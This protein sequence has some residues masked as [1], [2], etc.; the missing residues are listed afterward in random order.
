VS[1]PA[2][3]KMGDI[4]E[5]NCDKPLLKERDTGALVKVVIDSINEAELEAIKKFRTQK[6]KQLWM[7]IE[8]KIRPEEEKKEHYSI[9][10]FDGTELIWG[11]KLLLKKYTKE[12]N[13]QELKH[14]QKSLKKTEKAPEKT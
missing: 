12:I 2:P 3:S 5:F 10:I 8:K 13:S 14:P 1:K 9:F 4:F 11:D 6:Q 7:F